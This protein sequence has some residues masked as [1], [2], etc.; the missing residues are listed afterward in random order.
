MFHRA[1]GRTESLSQEAA[2]RGC[3]WLAGVRNSRKIFA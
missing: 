3:R 2:R 1:A